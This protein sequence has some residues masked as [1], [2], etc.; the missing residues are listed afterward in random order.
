MPQIPFHVIA[1]TALL[2]ACATAA[3]AEAPTPDG[4][5]PT[6]L[7]RVDPARCLKTC[8]AAP[9][10]T[11]RRLDATGSFSARGKHRVEARAAAALAALI[12]D[13]REAGFKLRINSAYRS[14]HDQ[15]RMFRTIK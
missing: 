11:M 12:A 13:A 9:P 3:R 8:A 1:A 5:E 2:V 6:R 7:D 15:A 10:D 4:A 14:Y